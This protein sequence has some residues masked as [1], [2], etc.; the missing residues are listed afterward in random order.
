[1]NV[2][3]DE[4]RDELIERVAVALTP[5]PSMSAGASLR[6]MAAVRSRRRPSR[7]ELV[8]GGLRERSVSLSSA[9]M[10]MAAA[11]VLGFIGR[12]EGMAAISIALL[13]K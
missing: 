1:M 4:F 8:L 2:E 9:G 13:K 10:L 12:G 11:L 3:R 7:F 5:L 6:I